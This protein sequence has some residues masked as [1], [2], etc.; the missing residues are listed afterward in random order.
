[1]KLQ[2]LG[3]VSQHYVL[4][5][6]QLAFSTLVQ[7][8]YYTKPKLGFVLVF[9]IHRSKTEGQS[10]ITRMVVHIPFLIRLTQQ[11]I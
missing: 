6:C 9:E 2:I 3:Y 10:V 8:Q 11:K 7:W 5:Y 1:M 4:D